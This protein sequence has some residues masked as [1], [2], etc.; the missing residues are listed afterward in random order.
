[1]LCLSCT[2]SKERIK[3]IKDYESLQE[4]RAS[5]VTILYSEKALV[6]AN[7]FASEFVRN[8]NARPPFTELRKKVRVFFYDDQKKIKST[9]YAKYA[10]MYEHNKNVIIRDSIVV[11]NQKGEQLKTEELVWNEQLRKF[12][13]NKPVQ[14]K[15]ATQMIYGNGLEANEDF[16]Y[17]QI[18]QI[19]GIVNLTN[20]SEL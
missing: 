19:K 1:M 18:T 20:N 7:L 10:R 16:S 9:L 11:I 15:T 2:N 12:F 13:T 3:H 4:D 8:E 17:Y 6:K 5:D 14:I